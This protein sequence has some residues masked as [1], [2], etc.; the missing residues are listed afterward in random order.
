VRPAAARDLEALAALDAAFLGGS[1]GRQSLEARAGASDAVLLA[2]EMEDGVVA[3]FALSRLPVPDE[4]EI[5]L[6]AVAEPFRRRGCGT[7][8]LR[9]TLAELRRRGVAAAYLSVREGNEAARR[10]YESAGFAVSRR[11]PR[12]YERPPEGGLEMTRRVDGLRGVELE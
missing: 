8:L 7:A 11:V 3:G 9:A 6:V 4:A 1:W 10:L 5:L 12:L 2:A